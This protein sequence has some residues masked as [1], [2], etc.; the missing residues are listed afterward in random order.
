M[1]PDVLAQ[2]LHSR[3]LT[4]TL[5]Q[6]GD[7]LLDAA[8][9]LLDLRKR[10]FVPVGGDL[11]TPGIVHHMLLDA[12]VDPAPPAL[13][14]IAARQ[15]S[16]AFEPS[17]LTA[18]ES[19]RDP[20]GRIAALS[21]ARLD[22][23]FA[24]RLSSELGG[25]L[26]CSHILTLGQLLGSSVGWAL[27]RGGARGV[28]PL[29]RPGERIYRRDITV[30]GQQRGPGALEFAAQLTDLYFAPAPAT[31]RPMDR[32]AGVRELRVWVQVD[33]AGVVVTDVRAAE[34]RRSR[35]DLAADAWT[36]RSA[37]AAAFVGLSLFRGVSAALLARFGD[38]PD[39]RP[40][41]DTLLMIA[42]TF[43]Q[44]CAA[45]SEKWPTA[46]VDADSLVGMGGIPD[47]CY[48]WRRGGALD[49]ARTPNDPSPVL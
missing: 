10:G 48:M 23:D 8:A 47:S 3:A 16:V 2:P 31:A 24:K 42:P 22:A 21:G 37:P 4:V 1:S 26:G 30:D 28:D 13:V 44:V 17:P 45:L 40:L 29:R 11:G 15:P 41:L 12:V 27:G 35:A 7:G 33:M 19:C 9:V 20:G 14:S 38:T 49:R 6:R 25:P 36:D 5:A 46:A 43:I 18:G 39:E 32:F 34:R